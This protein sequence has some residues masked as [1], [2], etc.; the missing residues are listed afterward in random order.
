MDYYYVGSF[1]KT[2]IDPISACTWTPSVG[3]ANQAKLAILRKEKRL[4]HVTT[5][6]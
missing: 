2:S 1:L 5:F 6:F 3:D 4:L